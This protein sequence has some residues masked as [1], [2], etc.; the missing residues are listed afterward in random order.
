MKHADGSAAFDRATHHLA[1]LLNVSPEDEVYRA[2]SDEDSGVGTQY[3]SALL[4]DYHQMAQK[5]G[6]DAARTDRKQAA[7]AA[8]AALVAG[9]LVW[10]GAVA[11]GQPNP[12]PLLFA[13]AFSGALMTLLALSM[14]LAC[15]IEAVTK[16]TEHTAATLAR[17]MAVDFTQMVEVVNPDEA[18]ALALD[19][20]KAHALTARGPALARARQ[21]YYDLL[22]EVSTGAAGTAAGSRDEQWTDAWQ[23]WCAIDDAWTDL[24]C[25]PIAALTHAELLDVTLPRT[26]AFVTAYADARDAMTGRTAATTPVDLSRLIRL[27]DT[28]QTAWTE[29]H[30]HAEHA[31]YAWLPEAERK[32]AATAEAAMLLAI[33]KDAPMGERA[34]AAAQAARLMGQITTVRLPKKA[35]GELDTVA[36]KAITA[37]P[38]PILRPVTQA[39]ER[40]TA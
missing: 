28:T 4:R 12:A 24:M 8:T 34:N 27:V 37:A 31:G 25:D 15:I 38:A 21:H 10:F 26:A 14:T 36:R 13:S 18:T 17:L 7:G 2:W 39:S 33:D 19:R 9:P 40:L 6:D 30:E 5:F 29:A 22:V 11:Y 1:P 35:R 23:R 16:R 3:D 20:A 32:K